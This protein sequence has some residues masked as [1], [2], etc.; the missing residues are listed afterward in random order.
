MSETENVKEYFVRSAE[1]FDSL[2]S[3]EK[4]SPLMRYINKKFR[5]DIYERFILSMKHVQKYKLETVLDIGCG[6]GRYAY[7]F[8]QICIRQIV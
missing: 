6:S 7:D 8:A 4:A 1:A 5:R 3:E 2:Y